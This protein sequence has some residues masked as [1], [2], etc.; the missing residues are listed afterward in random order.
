[1]KLTDQQKRAIHCVK[2]GHSR[3]VTSCFGY[4]YCARCDN[5]IGDTLGGMFSLDRHVVVGHVGRDDI[6]GCNCAVNYESLAAKHKK[7]VPAKIIRKL[8]IDLR[9][10][11]KIVRAAIA[12]ATVD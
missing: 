3:I 1:M 5:R 6:D 8:D 4:V 7:M 10:S 11:K 9:K 12:K 2:H